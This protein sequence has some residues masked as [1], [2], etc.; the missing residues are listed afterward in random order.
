MN[1]DNPVE[2]MF[3]DF[4]SSRSSKDKLKE[5]ADNLCEM[6][7]EDFWDYFVKINAGRTKYI[8]NKTIDERLKKMQ[9]DFDS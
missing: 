9:A 7:E 2:D 6:S 3:V 5:L 1:E 4:C 8:K